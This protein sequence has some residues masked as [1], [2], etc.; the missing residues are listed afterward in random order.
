MKAL[1]EINIHGRCSSDYIVHYYDSFI[2]QESKLNIVL[3]YW[4]SGD[5]H[6]LLEKK[7][8]YLHESEI[9]KFFIQITLG[10]HH[11]HTQNILHRDLKS[12]N[13]FLN[14]GS[15][16]RIG[17]LGSASENKEDNGTDGIF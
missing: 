6:S 4:D 14:E 10:L 12:L 2:D 13:I 9:W 5:L 15:Q 17:D 7:Q 16:A 11:L 8:E 3:E 1:E